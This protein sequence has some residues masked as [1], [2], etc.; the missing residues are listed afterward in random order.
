MVHDLFNTGSSLVPIMSQM[1]PVHTF[2][3]SY[4]RIILILSPYVLLGPL[5]PG[6]LTNILYILILQVKE[7]K[8]KIV[9]INFCLS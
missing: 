7:N 5:P 3:S 8:I 4:L 2:L 6:I 1:D 9:T